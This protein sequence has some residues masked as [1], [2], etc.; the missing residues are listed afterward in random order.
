M[1][2]NKGILSV[3]KAKKKAIKVSNVKKI[4]KIK[5]VEYVESVIVWNII[6]PYLYYYRVW[7]LHTYKNSNLCIYWYHIKRFTKP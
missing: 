5:G 3:K 6:W 2:E 7:I 1:H 4:P